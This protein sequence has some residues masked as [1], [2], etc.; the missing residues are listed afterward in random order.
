M[1]GETTRTLD[2]SMPIHWAITLRAPPTHWL[3]SYT[4]RLS[5][6]H[7]AIQAW[8]SIGTLYSRGVV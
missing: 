6:F 2:M 3:D 7:C 4:V 8:G 1:N 5:P